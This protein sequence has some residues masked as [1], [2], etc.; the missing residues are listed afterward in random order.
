[1]SNKILIAVWV[2]A[3]AACV[4]FMRFGLSDWMNPRG[5]IEYYD[6]NPM[7][8]LFRIA[9]GVIMTMLTL[10]SAVFVTAKMRSRD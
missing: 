10:F 3:L 8:P 7:R 9:F 2:V 4:W 1:M 5:A 6:R